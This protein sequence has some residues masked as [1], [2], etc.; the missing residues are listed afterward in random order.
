VNGRGSGCLLDL[1]L[2]DPASRSVNDILPNGAGKQEGFLLY[3]SDL[4]AK[5]L[6]RI[7]R[8]FPAVQCQ[9][10][11]GVVVKPGQKINQG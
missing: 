9:A 11:P 1:L 6:E 4:P 8:Q 10:A 3:D 2:A 7:F 5:L